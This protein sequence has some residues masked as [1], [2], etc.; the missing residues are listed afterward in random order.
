MVTGSQD[1]AYDDFE[2]DAASVFAHFDASPKGHTLAAPAGQTDRGMA[3]RV[4]S[5]AVAHLTVAN[6]TSVQPHGY[7]RSILRVLIS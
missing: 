5:D 2:E 4:T 7:D 1:T 6:G 3:I